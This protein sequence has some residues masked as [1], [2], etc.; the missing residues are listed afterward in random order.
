MF[1]ALRRKKISSFFKLQIFLFTLTFFQLEASLASGPG[2]RKGD[3]LI[4]P[5]ALIQ[6]VYDNNVY[7]EAPNEGDGPNSGT[8]FLLGTG[9]SL[10]NRND[11]NI[12]IKLKG[13]FNFRLQTTLDSQIDEPK[14]RNGVDNASLK[15]DFGF[16]P[17]SPFSVNLDGSLKYSERAASEGFVGYQKLE[18]LGGGEMLFHPGSNPSSRALEMNLGYHLRAVGLDVGDYQQHRSTYDGRSRAN[19]LSNE[20]NF[21]TKWKFFPKTAAILDFNFALIDYNQPAQVVDGNKVASL[22][23]DSSPFTAVFS[24]E[25]LVTQRISVDMGVGF[26]NTF[27]ALGDSYQGVI[28]KA[29]VNYVFEPSLNFKLGYKRTASD[30]SFSNYYTLH[31]LFG[32]AEFFLINKLSIGAKASWYLYTYST[33]GSASQA[34]GDQLIEREDPIVNV[35]GRL[36]Y[37]LQ[38]WAQ[39]TILWSLENNMSDWVDRGLVDNPAEYNRQLFMVKLSAQ[40]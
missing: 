26:M 2:I 14:D 18:L 8:M 31:N 38:E 21:T 11:N 7:Y 30:T 25:G 17:K 5:N 35:E 9:L 19:K 40:Y 27:N 16:M 10:A 28:A 20:F 1:L 6:G 34:S 37:A 32:N 36:S 12:S 3:F 33:S 24:I 39:A 15:L 22:D 13:D 23:R 4:H 29:V